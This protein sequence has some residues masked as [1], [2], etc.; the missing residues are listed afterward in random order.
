MTTEQK[1]TRKLS[2]I[3]SADVKGYS[4]LMTND[5]FTTIKTLKEYRKIMTDTINIYSGRVVDAP[6]DNIMAEFSS[7]VN[8]VQCSVEI[9]KILKEKNTELPDD[10]RLEFRIGVNIGDVV[11]DGDSLYGEG[12]NIAARIEGLA[13][14]G[15]V[16]ISRGAYDHIRNKLGFGYEYL[17]EHDVKNIKHP[18]R[19]YK[20]LTSQEDAGKLVGEKPKPVLKSWVWS[21]IVVAAIILTLIGYQLFQKITTPEF[22]PA[23]IE[24]MAFQLPEDPSIA[25]LPFENITGDPT[26][27]YLGEGIATHLIT[28]LA[29]VPKLFVISQYT[30][31]SYKGKKIKIKEVA[32]E[33]GVRYIVR[34]SVQKLNDQ[35]RITSQLIDA[36]S[37][38]YI[39][40]KTFDGH[41]NTFFKL[42]DDVAMEILRSLK[43]DV[44][45]GRQSMYWLQWTSN[46]PEANKKNSKGRSLSRR[47]NKDRNTKARKLFEEAIELDPEYIWP[48][49]SLGFAHY[50][51]FVFGYTQNRKKSLTLAYK[52]AVKALKIDDRIDL[53]HSL[54]SLVYSRMGKLEKALYEAEKAVELNPNGAYSYAILSGILSN[55]GRYE[56][57][58]VNAKKGI[59]R[60]PNPTAIYYFVLGQAYFMIGNYE[61]ALTSFKT[62]I[63]VSPE[64]IF[65]YAFCAATYIYLDKSQKAKDEVKKILTLNPKFNL[66]SYEKIVQYKIKS[67]KDKYINA[68]RKAG[69]PDSPPLSLP[70]KPSIAVLPFDNMSGDPEQEYFSDGITEDIITT[71]SKTDQLFVIARNSTFTYK[72]KPVKIKQVAKELGVRYV[73]EGSVRKSEDKIRITAQLIDATTGHHLW[74]ERYDRDLK[75]IFAVQDE[76]TMKI[77]T[78]LGI[79]LTHGEQVRIWAKRIKRIDV[80]LK[81]IEAGSLWNKGTNEAIIRYGQIGQE[82]ID[83]APDLQEGYI[84]LGWYHWRLAL[85]GKSPQDSIAKAFEFGQKA[86]SID[87]S[88]PAV[89]TLLGGIYLWMK[90]YE[91]A[92]A[93]GKRSVELDPNGALNHEMLGSTLCYADRQDEALFHIKQG[94]RLNPFPPHWYF[95]QLGRCYR[96]KGQYEEALTEYKKAL[97]LNPNALFNHV[98]LAIIYILLDRQE[99]AAASAKKVLETNPNFSVAFASKTWPYKN[100][101]RI[102]F[103]AEA[104]RKAGLPD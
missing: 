17:G 56:E 49:V 69:I 79:K 11:Q 102:E 7:V 52:N 90:Q 41:S 80:F 62:M 104:M 51:D 37:G 94:I 1:V 8:A 71:L 82:I 20:I 39:W 35:V 26:Q 92:I 103:I 63:D 75:D 58:I 14:P 34:G 40:A 60:D 21:T 84:M 13:E 97:H 53:G 96:E 76:I 4:V 67:D 25:V 66:A 88:N 70:D 95:T 15:G 18:V 45:Y 30:T 48:Y 29:P 23:S 74:A 9:Q 5:E 31:S 86:I 32:E 27:A 57:A 68:L 83:M 3:L 59:R 65:G 12:V 93:S 87:E 43:R 47:V 50:W 46:I 19:V 33:L 28:T 24:K 72:G 55:V 61:K 36:V 98:S 91:K 2:A 85:W 42:Q 81:A 10:K 99:E 38:Q 101:A 89:H 64:N 44:E 22:E 6:G 78:A 77:V 54:M 100:K 16:C 73:L